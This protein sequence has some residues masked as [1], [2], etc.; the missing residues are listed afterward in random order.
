MLPRDSLSRDGAGRRP[1]QAQPSALL[2]TGV[3]QQAHRGRPGDQGMQSRAM[4][5]KGRLLEEKVP[6]LA[7]RARGRT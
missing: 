3:A 2:S 4:L 7:G 1:Q 5:L 6:A